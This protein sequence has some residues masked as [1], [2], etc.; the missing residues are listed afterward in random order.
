MRE[1]K[2]REFMLATGQ[3]VDAHLAQISPSELLRLATLESKLIAEESAEVWA[4]FVRLKM[5]VLDGRGVTSEAIHRLLKELADL[6]YVVSH[7]ANAFGLPLQEAFNEVHTSNM[8]KLDEDGEAIFRADG[9][10]LKSSLYRPA[11]LDLIVEQYLD[12]D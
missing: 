6:Q 8:S 11:D 1:R 7:A 12:L 3:T 2:V 5:D 9:K 10:V 4:E